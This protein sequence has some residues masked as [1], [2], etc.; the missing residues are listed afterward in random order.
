MWG[1]VVQN[2]THWYRMSWYGAVCDKIGAECNCMVIIVLQIG[3][4]AVTIWADIPF[5]SL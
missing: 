5:D 1:G 2:V 4:I 3:S